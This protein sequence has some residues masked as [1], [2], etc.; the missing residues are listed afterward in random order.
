MS[1]F[2]R[3]MA[4]A[5]CLTALL[6]PPL[7][8]V[9]FLMDWEDQAIIYG[10]GPEKAYYPSFLFDAAGFPDGDGAG[11]PYRL[12]YASSGGATKAATSADAVLYT[13]EPGIDVGV[14]N[15]NHPAVLSNGSV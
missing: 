11:D 12:W 8:G 6:A 3:A 10:A 7:Q 5:L 14:A 13:P 9:D 2:L 4:G 1:S 15:S